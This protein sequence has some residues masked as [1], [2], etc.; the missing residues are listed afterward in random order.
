MT[1]QRSATVEKLA[2]AMYEAGGKKWVRANSAERSFVYKMAEAVE[3]MGGIKDVSAA[4][5][6]EL[7]AKNFQLTIEARDLRSDLATTREALDDVEENLKQVTQEL[8]V[9]T[10]GDPATKLAIQFLANITFDYDAE[11]LELVT[12]AD[13]LHEPAVALLRK[14]KIW[15]HGPA[16]FDLDNAA[17]G[18]RDEN[19]DLVA[20]TE[21]LTP[22]WARG[23]GFEFVIG[24]VIH[25]KPKP[26]T[27]GFATVW[28]EPNVPVLVA[29]PS[30]K[31]GEG[32]YTPKGHVTVDGVTNFVPDETDD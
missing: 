30:G 20:T 15:V 27:K 22:G 13:L 24:F 8:D 10:N 18:I 17:I 26:G 21:P 23:T 16:S 19:D 12:D 4:S 29:D 31:N 2:K 1:E 7:E 5:T 3:G 28:G 25:E 14:D 6:E 11:D 32:F 9:A